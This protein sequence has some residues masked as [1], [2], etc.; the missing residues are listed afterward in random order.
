MPIFTRRRLFIGVPLVAVLLVVG[1]VVLFLVT[2]TDLKA[3]SALITVGMTHE[4]VE[5]LLGPPVLVLRRADDKGKLMC[6]VDQL[7]QV[8]VRT[9]ADGHVES[10]GCVPSHSFIRGTVGRAIPLPQ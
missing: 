3:R 1:L 4:Q 2:G 6:W 7:W 10:V 8:D 9:D 5:D